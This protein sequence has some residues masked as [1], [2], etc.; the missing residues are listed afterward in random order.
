MVPD[1]MWVM[2]A[3]PRQ[4]GLAAERRPVPRPAAGEV[5]L[6]VRACGVCRTDLHNLD[7]D[8]PPHRSRG[9]PGPEIVGEVVAQ[10][11]G[12]AR[13][14]RTWRPLPLKTPT[15]PWRRCVTGV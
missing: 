7:G 6:R 1:S 11:A 15:R 8:L 10:G 2:A 3:D 5:L 9:V 14:A 12:A 13:C 4:H